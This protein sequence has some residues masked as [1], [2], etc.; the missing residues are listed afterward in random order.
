M[1]SDRGA[2]ASAPVPVTR[3]REEI[4]AER[5]QA[6]AAARGKVQEESLTVLAFRVGAERYAIQAE[7]V[8]QVIEIKGLSGLIGSP[9]WLLGAMLARS[10]IVPV[11]DLR[12]LI[13][14]EGG[15]L[16]DLT[17]VLV[18][19]QDG[20]VFGL[21][22]ESVEG[23]LAIPVRRLAD[24]PPSGPFLWIGPDRLA[25]LDLARLGIPDRLRGE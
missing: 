10:R 22:I 1:T 19:D 6:I 15:G 16:S 5:A 23:Q 9:P 21:A 25:I 14:L 17:R 8:A 11:L 7:E 4:L 24:P 12:H 13:G 3:R 18:L 2:P 20:D